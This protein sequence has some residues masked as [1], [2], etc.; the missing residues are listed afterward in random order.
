MKRG[1]GLRGQVAVFVIVAILIVG[2]GG[3]V[4][5]FVKV[6]ND[7]RVNEEFF[8]QGEIKIQV[9]NIESAVLNCVEDVGLSGLEVIGLQGGYYNKPVGS[10]EMEEGFIPYY[11][12]KGEFLMP[13][14]SEIEKEL[15]EYVSEEF[16]GCLEGLVFEGFDLKLGKG[17]VDVVIGDDG[18]LF[19][20]DKS[21][22]IEKD[23]RR[24]IFDLKEH[25][26]S[27]ESALSDILEVAEYLTESHNENEGM[28]C[29]SCVGEMA[30]ERDVYVQRSLLSGGKVLIII[31][32]N[33]T[34][35]ESYLFNFLNRYSGNES[36]EF[37]FEG[38]EVLPKKPSKEI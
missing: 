16:D 11:Y 31:G 12:D 23:G 9:D 22:R 32:E 3:G 7:A 37:K 13:S 5:Y 21:V 24:V 35:D 18:V 17:D 6:K 2:V 15:E 14:I 8:S 19:E 29:I 25:S 10:F 38:A 4:G 26:L 27:V 1:F 30:D 28:Y 36:D 34:G 20:I 33:R